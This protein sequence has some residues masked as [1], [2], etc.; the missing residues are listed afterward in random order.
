MLDQHVTTPER[1]SEG[2]IGI[3]KKITIKN[4]TVMKR[5]SDVQAWLEGEPEVLNKRITCVTFNSP[6][7]ILNLALEH[8][9]GE[10]L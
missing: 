7:Y 6:K 8:T 4:N 3:D 5:R 1:K 9:S 10:N 2:E